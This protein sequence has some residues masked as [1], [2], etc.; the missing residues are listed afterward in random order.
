MKICVCG[1]G[2][3]GKS[4]VTCLLAM[5]F[6]REGKNPVVLDSDE[7]NTSLFWM[8][9][10]AAPPRNLMELVGGKKEVQRKMMAQFS[11][12]KDEPAMTLWEMDAISTPDIPSD[13]APKKDGITLVATG[14][15]LQALEGCACPMG[16]ISKEFLRKY[17]T[18]ENEVMLVDME[19]GIEHFGRGLESGVDRVI[20]VVEPS[21]ESVTLTQKIMELGHASGAAFSGAVLNK[22]GSE[23]QK[24][25]LAER[26]SDRGVPVVG[27]IPLDEALQKAGLDGV[28]LTAEMIPEETAPIVRV[29]LNA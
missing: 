2:G 24:N 10:F 7:S 12:G 21:L 6:R 17:Q 15:I 8:L 23:E 13:F 19:A 25:R 14:K 9:G 11:K 28:P 1:K 4:T 3:S 20:S 27:C 16:T 29:L 18:A 26:L 22:V 5:A